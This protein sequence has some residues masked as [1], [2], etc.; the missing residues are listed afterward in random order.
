MASTRAYLRNGLPALYQ[1]GDF[2]MRFVGA[3]EE[4]LDPI[5]AI[6]DA[7][8]S[9][10]DPNFAPPDILDLLA[11]WLGRGPRRDAGHQ[12]PARDGP[13]VGRARP[14]ARHRQGPGAGAEA[15]FPPPAHAR[16]G[17]RRCDL[18]RADRPRKGMRRRISSSIAIDPSTQ[19]C[20]PRSP[21]CIEQ[22]KPVHSDVPAAREGSKEEGRVMRTCQSCGKENPDDQDFC[23][24]GEYLRW[25]PTGYA[26]PAITP[27]QVQ[28]QDSRSGSASAAV[29]D[30][31]A[32]RLARARERPGNGNGHRR[33][34]R[35]RR[36]RP[37][38]RCPPSPRPASARRPRRWCATCRPSRRQPAV[39]AVPAR[40]A[41]QPRR[42]AWPTAATSCRRSRRRSSCACTSR[43]TPPRARR[44]DQAVEP[45]Q[46]ERVLALVRNQSGIVDNYDLRVEG[47]PGRLVVDLPRHGLPRAVRLGR[48]LR[49]GG[50]GPPAPAAHARRPRRGCGSSR[51][52]RTPRR[53]GSS[54]PP[55]P[56]AL[57]IGAYDRDTATTLRPQRTPRPPQGHLRRP[58]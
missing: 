53:A 15:A 13:A 27:D 46:R 20:R 55:P 4:L 29:R 25:E 45:G 52:S 3:L 1:D 34:P 42:R 19:T 24:C 37:R 21:A 12:A 38:R 6:L 16:R 48:D 33:P 41:R 2:G 18:A 43:A 9:H 23:S 40:G 10:F 5:V 47:M 56:L 51:S 7:L 11:A 8:P 31:G 22:Y 39:P 17:Q 57:H 54:R 30:A 50:R 49:A 35:P 14:P 44:C 36:R 58:R 26:M 32:A 28:P